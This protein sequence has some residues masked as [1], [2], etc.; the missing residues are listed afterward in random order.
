MIVLAG[1]M[2]VAAAYVFADTAYAGSAEIANRVEVRGRDTQGTV[3]A[4]IVDMPSAH[5]A[6][7]THRWDYVLDYSAV[8]MLP[9]VELGLS[10]QLLQLADIGATWHSRR[11][12][13][14]LTEYGTYGQ[15]NSSYL[16]G[17]PT[18][19]ISPTTPSVPVGGGTQLLAPPATITYG[20]SRTVLASQLVLSRRWGATASVEYS[21]QGGLDAASRA[22]LPF[23]TGPRADASATY[24]LT[25]VDAL[26]TRASA[27]ART[28]TSGPCSPVAIGVP[29]GALC[30][31]SA[32]EALATETWRH[33]LTRTW[34]TA[35]GGGAGL[36][37][38]RLRDVDPYQTFVFPIG[39]ASI[40]HATG[41]VE[42]RNVVRLEALVSPV[43]DVRLGLLDERAQTMLDVTQRW[44][45]THLTARVAGA[46]T[47][48]S[49]LVQPATVFQS[50]L[51]VEV[52]LSKTTSAGGGIWYFW[53]EQGSLGTF[54]GGFVFVGLTVHTPELHF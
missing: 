42:K 6:V 12:R 11:V 8:A 2:H 14:G 37:R 33:R 5:L 10:P 44:K 17:G 51:G 9:G 29:T 1:A 41:P 32:Q 4:D 25:R 54:S 13:I 24:A 52:D 47:I 36:V 19:T 22:Y 34:Q 48:D 7:S 39:S 49:S 18:T 45:D 50:G 23:V 15:E 26:E 38:V 40:E 27:L 21:M 53:Q 31:A 28:A 16:I 46:R 3:G 35:L 20:S 43:L 30:D